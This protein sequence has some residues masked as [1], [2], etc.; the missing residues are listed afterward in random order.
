MPLRGEVSL[1]GYPLNGSLYPSDGGWSTAPL[2]IPPNPS[3]AQLS[4]YFNYWA[5]S[6]LMNVIIAFSPE[7]VRL[8]SV[9]VHLVAYEQNLK[10]GIGVTRLLPVQV[11][12]PIRKMTSIVI[13]SF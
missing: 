1:P 10:M 11:G 13:V 5:S 8:T 4:E 12:C 9:C 2:P 7:H 3:L 6:T